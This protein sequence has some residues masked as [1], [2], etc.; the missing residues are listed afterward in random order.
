MLLLSELVACRLGVK[1][2]RG[3]GGRVSLTFVRN[4]TEVHPDLLTAPD[5]CYCSNQASLT[6]IKGRA[7]EFPV[8]EISRPQTVNVVVIK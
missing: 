2:G 7:G 8:G 4:R 3:E 5:R 6:R 1:H